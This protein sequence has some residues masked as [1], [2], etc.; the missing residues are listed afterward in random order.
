MADLIIG[1]ISFSA[2]F[3]I[4]TVMKYDE[5][6]ELIQLI[7]K[8]KSQYGAAVDLCSENIEGAWSIFNKYLDHENQVFTNVASARAGFSNAVK[9]GSPEAVA[10]A[11]T[12][13]LNATSV[14]ED[15]PVLK[16]APLAEQTLGNLQQQVEIINEAVGK[17][18]EMVETYNSERN[19]VFG[20]IV[21][22]FGSFP[23]EFD[24][25]IGKRDGLDVSEIMKA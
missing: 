24:Y 7:K 16:S 19:S 1:A 4:A 23:K 10:Q 9:S 6:I 12:R 15:Y 25:Y 20:S 3:I 14:T 18:T 17:W 11:A 5:M 22:R 13:F 8:T 21:A 2:V